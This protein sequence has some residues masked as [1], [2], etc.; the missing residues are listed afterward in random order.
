MHRQTFLL[1][2]KRWCDQQNSVEHL[3]SSNGSATFDPQRCKMVRT[4]TFG[5]QQ[6]LK[7][8]QTLKSSQNPPKLS[9][10]HKPP[11]LQNSKSWAAPVGVSINNTCPP[12]GVCLHHLDRPL[13]SI[14]STLHD[15][16]RQL[17][18]RHPPTEAGG[19]VTIGD[20]R[21]QLQRKLARVLDA[22]ENTLGGAGALHGL[23]HHDAGG[24]DLVQQPG[25][26]ARAHLAGEKGSSGQSG[27]S[28]HAGNAA[29]KCSTC[30]LLTST[31]S[32]SNLL[33]TFKYWRLEAHA[34][35]KHDEETLGNEQTPQI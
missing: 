3:T 18:T 35:Y 26:D 4:K 33:H 14:S 25:E 7:T 9:K 11:K 13:Q 15:A 1:E 30:C 20:V 31:S 16:I 22:L 32:D 34:R 28:K 2:C 8:V 27:G 6:P 21:N 5:N 12:P 17:R 19:R 29:M 24:Q 10:L 23:L